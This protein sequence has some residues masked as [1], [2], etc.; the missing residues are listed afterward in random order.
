MRVLVLG[1][2][3]MLGSALFKKYSNDVK[4]I[5]YGTV[6][7]SLALK[8]FDTRWH[9]QIICNLDV[10]SNA[11]LSELFA[12]IKPDIVINC[13]G[14]VKQVSEAN[15][16]L[17]AIAINS[18]FPHRI[19]SLCGM[20]EARLVHISTDCVYSGRAGNYKES[21][22]ADA[23]DLYG[24]SKFLG[25]VDYPH[26]IT[27]RTSIIG[28]ELQGNRSLVNWFLT[29][30][31]PIQGY[32]NAIFSGLPTVELA[33][34]IQDFVIPNPELCGLFHVSVNPI[35]KYDLLN[36]V[37]KEYCKKIEIIPNSEFK[38]DR[39]L[40][41]SKFRSATGFIA[42]E[43]SQLIAEMHAFG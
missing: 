6:R 31:G 5:T 14:L 23:N 35:S 37:A 29:Q 27:L 26:A 22:F 34:V 24:R 19:A 16:P 1:I 36:I 7:N 4:M 18:L 10:D 39:S 41:S 8:Y 30:D 2:G 3:G 33:R 32:Q 11:S 21:D 40:N 9:K 28:H 20:F 43:W 38:I 13:I 12:R 25:E 42:K 17:Q 15:D